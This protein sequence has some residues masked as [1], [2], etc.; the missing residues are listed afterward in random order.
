MRVLAQNRVHG[1]PKTSP[2][3]RRD[4]GVAHSIP[5]TLQP[6]VPHQAFIQTDRGTG[7]L[8]RHV[9][10]CAALRH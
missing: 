1:G 5:C 6:S 10:F 4:S 9:P 3:A 7:S 2:E 8:V